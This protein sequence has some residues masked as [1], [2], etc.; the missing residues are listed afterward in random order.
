[1]RG[2]DRDGFFK[3]P[4]PD[5]EIEGNRRRMGEGEGWG[6]EMKKI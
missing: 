6:E 5:M 2:K 1:V 4:I 3:G